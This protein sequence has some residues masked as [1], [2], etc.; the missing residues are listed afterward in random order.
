MDA[1]HT[2]VE[3][4]KQMG[5]HSIP[6]LYDSHNTF[7]LP[8]KSNFL[9]LHGIAKPWVDQLYNPQFFYWDPDYLAEGGLHCPNCNTKLRHHGFT[10]PRHVVDSHER[11]YIIGQCYLC[12]HCKNPKTNEISVTCNSWDT[13]ILK[14][15]PMALQDEFPAYLSHQSAMANSLFALMHTCFQYGMGSKQF[16]NSLQM[17][18]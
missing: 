11:V 16:S 10:H 14:L 17:L 9:F 1:Y 18:H 12:P 15:L 4:L 5:P 6:K 3:F 8:Q 7:W 2:D 13:K